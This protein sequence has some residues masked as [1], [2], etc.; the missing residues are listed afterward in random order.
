MIYPQL[1][2]STT[3]LEAGSSKA[4]AALMPRL[5]GSQNLYDKLYQNI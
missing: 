5:Y 2:K 3:A 4:P 1:S